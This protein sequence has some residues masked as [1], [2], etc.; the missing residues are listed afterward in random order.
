MLACDSMRTSARTLLILVLASGAVAPAWAVRSGRIAGTVKAREGSG[1]LGAVVT[2]FKESTQGGTI[3][4]TRSDRH[5]AYTI[6]NL[7]PGA[8]HV[9][10][11]RPGYEPLTQ[12][13][14]KIDAGKTTTLDV[15]LQ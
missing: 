4:F 6:A 8:Y 9:Q 3:S 7:S 2:I 11:S 14:I 15:I 1:L 5:G 13:N 10:V 12:E